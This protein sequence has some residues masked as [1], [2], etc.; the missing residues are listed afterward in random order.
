MLSVNSF[1]ATII[2]YW[3]PLF[4]LLLNA[5]AP[6]RVPL[7]LN[8]FGL[9]Q[10]CHFAAP[11][12]PALC[13]RHQNIQYCERQCIGSQ[14]FGT[15]SGNQVSAQAKYIHRDLEILH[16]KIASP[17]V[18]LAQY[19]AG[20]KYM[21]FTEGYHTSV[22]QLQWIRFRDTTRHVV[23]VSCVPAQSRWQVGLTPRVHFV[24]P[25]VAQTEQCWCGDDTTDHSMHGS[26][27][28]C[29]VK[30]VGDKTQI[31]GGTSSMNVYKY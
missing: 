29:N 20:V 1:L 16:S 28:Q 12:F 27:A 7:L 22:V 26:S 31:C 13:C 24:F 14:Y 6:R 30:C 10:P 18:L 4:L 2:T 11:Y 15:Q 17:S 8:L 5:R 21:L 19:G 25:P 3:F 9:G 23:D